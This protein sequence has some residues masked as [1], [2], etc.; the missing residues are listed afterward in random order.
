MSALLY[1]IRKQLKNVIRGLAQ[2]PL[3]L[4]GYILIGM[5]MMFS[6][7]IVLIMP[8]GTVHNGDNQL[9]SAI[10][11]GLIV[12]AL[13]FSL[14]Q[15]IEKGSSYFRFSDVNL[16]FTA[17][18]KPSKVL[19]YG[20]IKH[21]GTSLLIVLFTVFQI[22]NVKNNFMLH[23]YGI[24]VIL[25]SVLLYS[26]LY[27][28]VGMLLYTF[29]S[30]STKRRT[31]TKRALDV[32]AVLFVVGFVVTVVKKQSL[33]DGAISYLNN[34][35][36]AW[37]PMIGQLRAIGI[38]AV[39]GIG[40]SFWLGVGILVVAIAAFVIVLY[41]SDMDYYEDVLDATDQIEQRIQAKRQGR[42]ASLTQRKARKVKGGF[43]GG[44]ARV[45]F[46]KSL[47]EYRKTS[48]FLFFDKSSV[49]IALAGLGFKFLM[50]D[51]E[52][53]IFFTL[54][55]SA[56]MLFFFIVQGKWPAELDKPYVFLIPESN[57]KKLLYTTLPENIKNLFDGVLLFTI[58]YFAFD[59]SLPVAAMCVVCYTLYGAVFIYAD[60]VSRRLFGSVHSKAM[61]IF[62]KLFVSFFV[63]IPGVIIMA[64]L[65]F[66]IKNDFVSVLGIAVWNLL[67][68]S[69]LFLA[70]SGIFNNLEVTA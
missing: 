5:L 38:A 22:P 50:P 27:P 51:G 33:L 63:V 4:I 10:F 28:I 43:S 37:M 24:W 62:I 44:G 42:D 29:S 9:F 39:Y 1:I 25:L 60:I 64:I 26:L 54:F 66:T 11:T 12:I 52:S 48:Y 34:D 8:S 58:S 30:V 6:L 35:V 14:K 7:V 45:I 31:L 3:A 57:G 41:N 13:Y 53:S 69:G 15:G 67:A 16:V 49:I 23:S 68:V 40:P 61:Q 17:P 47:L 55:F 2:K 46:E 21:M 65:A 70:S 18:F 32:L 59:V 56:Y 19:L 36:F 20:F